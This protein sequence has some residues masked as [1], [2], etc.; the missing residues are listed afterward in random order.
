MPYYI[1][2]HVVYQ[3]DAISA[4]A[5]DYLQKNTGMMPDKSRN[6]WPGNVW[7]A[8]GTA[9]SV[10]VFYQSASTI[11]FYTWYFTYAMHQTLATRSLTK[12]REK[13]NNRTN[14]PHSLLQQTRI[15]LGRF[16]FSSN[17]LLFR[18]EFPVCPLIRAKNTI[19]T[20]KTLFMVSRVVFPFMS[21]NT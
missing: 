18:F 14:M 17:P 12:Y 16:P 4:P 6:V 10:R 19:I 8:V 5:I 1:L 7:P 9:A 2:V 21:A 13:D 11:P 15:I 3:Q 20:Y